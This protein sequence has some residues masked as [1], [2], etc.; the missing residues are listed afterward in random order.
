MEKIVSYIWKNRKVIQQSLQ[1]LAIEG[2][3]RHRKRNRSN[4][5]QTEET[6]ATDSQKKQ[7]NDQKKQQNQTDQ[8]NQQTS[9][10]PTIE[11]AIEAAAPTVGQEPTGSGLTSP[12][13]LI[14]RFDLLMASKEAG[15]YRK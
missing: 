15:R 6:E 2:S 10:E 13:E 4:R 8:E 1:Q 3:N 9:E 14:D 5:H 12:E 11:A 7:Q